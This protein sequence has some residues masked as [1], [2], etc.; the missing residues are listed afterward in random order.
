M[1]AVR[2]LNNRGSLANRALSATTSS[3]PTLLV[4]NKPSAQLPAPPEDRDFV[5]GWLVTSI[6]SLLSYQLASRHDFIPLNFRT[7]VLPKLPNHLSGSDTWLTTLHVRLTTGGTLLVSSS[8]VS[9]PGLASV[10][11]SASVDIPL[12][13]ELWIAPGGKIARYLGR[14]PVT[15][16][17]VRRDRKVRRRKGTQR[18]EE[19][20]ARTSTLESIRQWKIEASRWLS[21]KGIQLDDGRAGRGWVLLE[22]WAPREA[23]HGVYAA[24]QEQRESARP[25]LCTILWPERLCFRRTGWEIDAASTQS[26]FFKQ[27][28]AGDD[29]L[30]PA[31]EIDS[32]LTRTDP[33]V[34]AEDWYLQAGARA[35]KIA[36][37]LSAGQTPQVVEQP[38]ASPSGFNYDDGSSG[39]SSIVTDSTRKHSTRKHSTSGKASLEIPEMTRGAAS[40]TTALKGHPDGAS[41]T[42]LPT[43]L[44]TP[45]PTKAPSITKGDEAALPNPTK[46]MQRGSVERKASLGTV[47]D[48][49]SANFGTGDGGMPFGHLDEDMFNEIGV[50]EEDFSFFDDPRQDDAGQQGVPDVAPQFGRI[51]LDET[52]RADGLLGDAGLGSHN[53]QNGDS[54]LAARSDW[55]PSLASVPEERETGGAA[56]SDLAD[57]TLQNRPL[58]PSTIM[59]R[60]LPEQSS[61]SNVSILPTA[62]SLE[63]SGR[64][65]KRRK[66]GGFEPIQFNT[67]VDETRVKYAPNGR[68][69]FP[70]RPK[71]PPLRERN[72]GFDHRIPRL[73]SAGLQEDSSSDDTSLDGTATPTSEVSNDQDPL[74][75]HLPAFVESPGNFDDSRSQ[76]RTLPTHSPLSSTSVKR[77]RGTMGVDEDAM[78]PWSN[79]GQDLP[80]I[81]PPALDCL[82]S[83]AGDWSMAGFFN[84]RPHQS[85]RIFTLSGIEFIETAQLVAMHFL[86]GMPRPFSHN[87]EGDGVVD[88]SM[89]RHDAVVGHAGRVVEAATRSIFADARD[90]DLA[91]Y[92]AVEDKNPAAALSSRGGPLLR[93]PSNLKKKTSQRNETTATMAATAAA[94]AAAAAAGVAAASETQGA[95]LQSL[96]PPYIRVRRG[97]SPLQ[98]LPPALYFWENFGFEPYSGPKDVTFFCVYPDLQG[99]QEP[100]NEFLDALGT[101]YEACRLGRH[102][103]GDII[104]YSN[105]C[106]P[107]NLNLPML[108]EH[109]VGSVMHCLRETCTSLGKIASSQLPAGLFLM[110]SYHRALPN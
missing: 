60:L 22:V 7:F 19:A 10:A 27:A 81:L 84:S 80:A 21:K 66:L 88:R 72:G 71:S 109:L 90:C 49:G 26:L 1:N 94:T 30:P 74:F 57:A 108:G 106:V 29:L 47:F 11:N 8:T 36:S 46:D 42:P 91:A 107:V 52:T 96:P 104:A 12:K 56:L 92:A 18:P 89:L 35:N 24:S 31:D 2:L 68:F 20:L 83:S 97:D 16:T 15:D 53:P 103:R 17:E 93:P 51:S 14:E 87:T 78:S 45:V 28:E 64:N 4:T 69:S 98:V 58:T 79:E 6:V 75:L 67:V 34:F 13:T 3:T 100:V 110:L 41:L 32:F 63:E 54:G 77:K 9:Q 59:K 23:H 99:I 86:S 76:T 48:L 105:G 73:D 95:S 85:G 82:D 50:T 25:M 39:V 33:L 65:P 61:T 70:Y 37:R 55:I 38:V 101:A 102:R 62:D 44:P 43:P 5:Y 40:A